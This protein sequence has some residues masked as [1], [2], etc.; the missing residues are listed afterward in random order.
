MGG[1]AIVSGGN[2]PLGGGTARRRNTAL[3]IRPTCFS[4]DLTDWSIVQPNGFPDY[5]YNDREI[6]RAFADNNV[7][8]Y[9]WLLAHGVTFADKAPDERGGISVG[10]SV[11]REMHCVPLDWPVA[12]TGKPVDP[13]STHDLFDRRGPDV[14][15]DR[16]GAALRRAHPARTQ[17]DRDP[18]RESERRPRD[19]HRGR[20]C[21]YP[22]CDPRAPSR[23]HRHRRLDRQRQLPPHVRS[24]P[25]RGI[26]R[27]RRNAMVRPGCQRRDCRD[28]HRCRTVGPRSTR[29]PSSAMASPRPAVSAASTAISICHWQPG[30]KVFE[31]ARATGLHVTDWQ[32]VILVNM[33]GQRFYD[34]TGG[35]FTANNYDRVKPYVAEQLSQRQEH[36]LQPQQLRQRRDGGHWGRTQRRRADLG[37]LRCRRRLSGKSG[38]PNLRSSMSLKVFSSPPV[39]LASSPRRSA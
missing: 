17:D 11:P 39:R 38:L 37:D 4:S 6:V 16:G 18:P 36:R 30:S 23:D 2:V 34:E 5:R 14:S 26:L 31:K 7:A 1:H 24:T 21:R 19:R 13:R 10:N 12:H 33:I 15:A 3:K 9:D 25:H 28:G 22:L 35:A 27:P 32:N 20:T 8:T 29:R